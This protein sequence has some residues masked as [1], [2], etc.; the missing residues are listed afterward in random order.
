[1]VGGDKTWR[2]ECVLRIGIGRND[3]AAGKMILCEK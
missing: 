1:M 2:R 3:V